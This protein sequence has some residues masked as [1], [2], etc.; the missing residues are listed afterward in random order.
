[1]NVIQLTDRSRNRG[2]T[3]TEILF[4]VM[5]LGIGFI[6]IA[7]MFPVA[8][9]QTQ[10]TTQETIVTGIAREG[11]AYVSKI[12]SS[13]TMP[14]TFP[15][16]GSYF[17][18][19]QPLGLIQANL[20]L[21]VPGDVFTFRDQRLTQLDPK[22][23]PLLTASLGPEPLTTWSSVNHN[24]ILPSDNRYAWFPMYRRDIIW[25]MVNGTTW[26]PSLA[27]YAQL[28]VIGV[29][30]R[31]QSAYD[32]TKTA[33][34]AFPD[35]QA[36]P[37]VAAKPGTF[38]PAQGAAKI[39]AENLAAGQPSTIQFLNANADVTRRAAEGAFVVIS[40]DNQRLLANEDPRQPTPRYRSMNGSVLRLGNSLGNNKFELAP[41]QGLARGQV[42]GDLLNNATVLLIGR[43]Y[44]NPSQGTFEGP[45]QDVAVYTTIVQVN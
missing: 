45:A 21:V 37:F 11:A 31:N 32:D 27:P 19:Q 44:R 8:I 23:L 33:S 20:V 4:A 14:P 18:P 13:A 35:V 7:A 28:I 30:N 34:A 38:E 2:F 42:R 24:L 43:G 15:R 29:Q 40:N 25:H 12:A 6:M 26:T 36:S 5:I 10:S 39:T 9:Q 16:D 17:R 1:M 3:F 22:V 41:G